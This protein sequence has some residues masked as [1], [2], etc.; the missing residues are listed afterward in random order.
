MVE[1]TFD[2]MGGPVATVVAWD[3]PLPSS[4]RPWKAQVESPTPLARHRSI[5]ET[6]RSG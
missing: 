2:A 4:V 5:F 1:P 6:L 3:I